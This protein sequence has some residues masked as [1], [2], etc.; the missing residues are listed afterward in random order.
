MAA[1]PPAAAG[2]LPPSQEG[3]EASAGPILAE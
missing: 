3:H 2:E 1:T